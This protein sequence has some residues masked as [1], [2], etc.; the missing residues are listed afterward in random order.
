LVNDPYAL[1]FQTMVYDNTVIDARHQAKALPTHTGTP[2]VFAGSTTGPKYTAKKCSPYQ[3]TWSVR[4]NCAKL[5]IASLHDW[6]ANGNIF[7]E[8]HSHGVRALVTEPELLAPIN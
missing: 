2:I 5:N 6:A 7:N 1:N 4:P 8:S 3:V